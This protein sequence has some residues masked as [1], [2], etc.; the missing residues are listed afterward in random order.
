M[1]RK[2][3]KNDYEKLVSLIYQVHQLHY[4]H[5]PDIYIEGNPWNKED[6]ESMMEDK[7]ILNLV[8]EEDG[9]IKGLLIAT[10]KNNK[11]N[12]I[13]KERTIYFIDD[14]VVDNQFKRQGIGTKL[15]E[16]LISIAKEN[17]VDSVELNVWAFN[18]DAI[19]FY[20]SL[21]MSVKNMKLEK[22]ISNDIVVTEEQNIKVTN[23][24]LKKS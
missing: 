12:S 21:G 6:F 14:I 10:Q 2:A 15:Y 4:E 20:E 22:I 13:S 1:I 18:S 19:K 17:K 23:N 5:R 11:T 16:H 9:K 24:V 3:N 8:Y 7:S